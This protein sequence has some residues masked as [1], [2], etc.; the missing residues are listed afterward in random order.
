MFT[1][2]CIQTSAKAKAASTIER[3]TLERSW[4]K[5]ARI[6]LPLIRAQSHTTMQRLRY[7]TKIELR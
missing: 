5:K 3:A 2:I 1:E 4:L 7:S 6:W